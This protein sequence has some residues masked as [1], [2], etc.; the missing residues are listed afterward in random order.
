MRRL[1]DLLY[2]RGATKFETND[3]FQLLFQCWSL[4]GIKP[5]KLYRLRGML[6]MCFCWF[7]LLLCP[8]TF[9]MGYLHTLETEPLTVQLNILQAICNIIGLPLKA[10]AITILLTHLR[11]AEP[12]FARLDA[13]YESVASREQIKNCVVVSTRL[14]ASVGL[15]FHFYGITTYLQA[16]LTRGYPMGEWLPFTDYIL[17]PTIRYW[18]HFIFEVFHVAFLLTVQTSMDVFPAV[19]IRNLRTHLKLLTERVS[20]LGEN[21]EFTDEENFDEL[22]DCIVTHQELLE[23]KNILS[24]VCS[25]TLFVQFVIA[26]IALCIALLNF[27]VFADTVQRVVTLLYYLGLIMQ[28]TPTCYQASMMEVDSAKLPDAIFHCNWLAMDKRSR[29]LIIYFI[30]RAQ[31]KISFVAL[32]LFNINLTTNLSIIKFGFSLYTFMNN[33]GFG[34]NLKELLE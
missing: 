6:H 4:V 24:S 27:F 21:P 8:F 32:K 3:G 29:K 12:I 2:G 5:L 28:I 20:H 10:I 26:A 7:L 31:E 18:A 13:R 9:F 22:V 19:Y 1:T 25:I 16:L 11:S 33:V 34:Q 17:R 30:H 23:A 14:L 15:M